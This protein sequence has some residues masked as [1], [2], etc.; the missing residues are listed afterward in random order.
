MRSVSPEGR[1]SIEEGLPS[2]VLY[3]RGSFER[4][5]RCV[6]CVAHFGYSRF[7]IIGIVLYRPVSLFGDESF[8]LG[9][10]RVRSKV[11]I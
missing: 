8:V 3:A 10:A 4:I 11:M 7:E 2:K 9:I 1:R 6:G 5:E